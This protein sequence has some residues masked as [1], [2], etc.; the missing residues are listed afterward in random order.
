M[1]KMQVTDMR[2]I[3]LL[4]LGCSIA[5][6]A[7]G[8]TKPIPY[9]EFGAVAGDGAAGAGTASVADRLRL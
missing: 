4:L 2:R 9:A 8:E 7:S 3:V 1:T 6:S 5:A